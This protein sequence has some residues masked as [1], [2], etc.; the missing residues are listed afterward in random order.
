MSLRTAPLFAALLVSLA[1][2]PA[3]AQRAPAKPAACVDFY[4]HANHDWLARNP[5]PAGA[6]AYS[7]WD[8]LAAL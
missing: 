4:A 7:R 8:E 5:L 1:A 3:A 2:A 6:K